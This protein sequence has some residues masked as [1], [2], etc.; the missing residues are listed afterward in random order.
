MKLK[1]FYKPDF[2]KNKLFYN[3]YLYGDLFEQLI[4]LKDMI[5]IR[6]GSGF[7]VKTY[8]FMPKNITSVE[9]EKTEFG[10]DSGI[11]IR[12]NI[13]KYQNIIIYRGGGDYPTIVEN[14][15]K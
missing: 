7:F 8:K 15:K 12:H 10:K 14:I 6:T 5:V 9:I 3:S 11:V 2:E 13:L 4:I 1:E